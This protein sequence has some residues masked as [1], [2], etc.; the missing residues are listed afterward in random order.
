MAGLCKSDNE[1]PGS[2]KASCCSKLISDIIIV[3]ESEVTC[4][5]KVC[6]ILNNGGSEVCDALKEYI[7]E[8]N[9]ID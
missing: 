2:L 8:N 4:C 3:N 5:E 7:D 9:K 6:E 1:P